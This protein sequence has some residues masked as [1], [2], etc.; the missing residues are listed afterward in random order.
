MSVEYNVWTKG[1]IF[2]IDNLDIDVT[3]KKLHLFRHRI[4]YIS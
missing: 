2:D 1:R 4:D 3:L